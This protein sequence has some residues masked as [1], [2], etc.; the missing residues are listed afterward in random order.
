PPK[1]VFKS[2]IS[3][4]L[5][6]LFMLSS[7]SAENARTF[8]EGDLGAD[9]SLLPGRPLGYGLNLA[10][11][12]MAQPSSDPGVPGA[13]ISRTSFGGGA[14]IR[15][16]PGAGTLEWSLGY[17]GRFTAFDEPALARDLDAIDHGA[18]LRGRWTFLPQTALLYD[19]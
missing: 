14:E 8:I 3:G 9:A 10:I 11:N 15:V 4:R 6:Q 18:N 7:G 17:D 19:G 1:L 12:R 2:Q 13:A 5:N 16:R